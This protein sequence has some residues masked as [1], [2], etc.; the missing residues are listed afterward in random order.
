MSALSNEIRCDSD[1]VLS[2]AE[3][4]RGHGD[5][6]GAGVGWVALRKSSSSSCE[7]TKDWT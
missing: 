1:G 6:D 2:S 7:E 5:G 3:T 4:K